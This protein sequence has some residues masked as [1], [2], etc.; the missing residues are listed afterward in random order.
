MELSD[1]IAIIQTVLA[2][3]G[4]IF[5]YREFKQWRIELLGTKEVDVALKLAKC[6]VKIRD[7]FFSARSVGSREAQEKEFE[8]RL[9]RIHEELQNLYDIR[10]DFEAL[11]GVEISDEVKIFTTKF[12]ELQFAMYDILHEKHHLENDRKLVNSEQPED[13]EF[14]QAIVT[15]S[16]KLLK[17]ARKYLKKS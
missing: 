10:W 4:F 5:A 16:D 6:V 2:L 17:M 3:G 14:G 13:D 9:A 1:T 8:Y 12:R 7:A 11:T 15:N